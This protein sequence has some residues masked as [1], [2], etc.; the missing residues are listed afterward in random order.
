MTKTNYVAGAIEKAIEGGWGPHGSVKL[1]GHPW[2]VYEVKANFYQQP[3]WCLDPNFWQAL[4]K[5][6]GEPEGLDDWVCHFNPP[7]ITNPPAMLLLWRDKAMHCFIDHLSE[8]KDPN[9]F[10]E[11]LLGNK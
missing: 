6:L 5:S 10:F 3:T 8:G 9:S 7:V 2:K 1:N 11:D 4:G